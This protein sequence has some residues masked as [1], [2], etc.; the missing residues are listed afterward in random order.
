MNPTDM[1]DTI[2]RLCGNASDGT[3]IGVPTGVLLAAVA[4]ME[5]HA[6]CYED[7]DDLRGDLTKEFDEQYAELSAAARYLAS[8]VAAHADVDAALDAL[9]EI[10]E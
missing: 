3:M 9:K 7:L 4:V 10:V 1:I 5:D 8:A 2:K 6:H